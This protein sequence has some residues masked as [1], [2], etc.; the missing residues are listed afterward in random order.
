M[1]VRPLST[2]CRSWHAARSQHTLCRGQATGDGQWLHLG[3]SRLRAASKVA[4]VAWPQPAHQQPLSGGMGAVQHAQI[5][6]SSMCPYLPG[7]TAGGRLSPHPSL[8]SPTSLTELMFLTTSWK[9]TRLHG[10]NQLKLCTKALGASELL[11]HLEGSWGAGPA[12]WVSP[13]LLQA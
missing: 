11:Q 12:A 7:C 3:C 13:R 8:S 6:Y 4:W 1:L 2:W 10:L 9:K 5:V